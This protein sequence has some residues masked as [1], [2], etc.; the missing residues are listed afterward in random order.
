MP[1]L[2]LGRILLAPLDNPDFAMGAAGD[3]MDEEPFVFM[4]KS[5]IFLQ[6]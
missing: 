3:P 1:T 5:N 2:A 6:S 4:L